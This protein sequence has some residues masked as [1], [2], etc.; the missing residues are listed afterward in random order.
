MRNGLQFYRFLR[1]NSDFRY[2]IPQGKHSTWAFRVN[3]GIAHAYGPSKSLPYEKF[4]FAG[5]SNSVRAWAPRRLGLGGSRDSIRTDGVYDYSYEQP[6]DI[7]LEAS[8]EYRRDIISFLEGAV[9]IDA[10]N[11]WL[12]RADSNNVNGDF[13]FNRFYK[14]IAVGGGVGLRF[15]FSF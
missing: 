1:F 7:L 2:Y 11:T 15:D 10:G 4:F 6:G 9:F 14:E 5:G 13:K 8:A 3:V 12:T